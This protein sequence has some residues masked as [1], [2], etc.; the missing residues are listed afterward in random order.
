MADIYI[1]ILFISYIT[2]YRIYITI[3]YITVY[4]YDKSALG[5]FDK[6]KKIG[7]NYFIYEEFRVKSTHIFRI[8]YT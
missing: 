1:V 7:F 4:M 5:V 2:I 6:Y 3:Y 8:N